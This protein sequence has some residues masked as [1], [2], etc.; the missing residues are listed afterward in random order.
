[1]FRVGAHLPLAVVSPQPWFPLQSLLRHFRPGTRLG[2]PAYA[3]QDGFDVWAP[4]FFSAPL[5]L[6]RLDGESMALG[7]WPRLQALRQAGRLDVLDAHF[8]YPDGY[9]GMRLKRRL[10]VPLTITMRGTEVRHARDPVLR[11]LLA[12]ALHGADRVFAVSE[13]LRQVA[14]DLG[15]APERTRVV[16]NGVDLSRFSRLPRD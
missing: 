14:L 4:R 8:G 13:S 3:C 9:A 15:V 16:G 5:L 12:Q 2:A 10:G 6:R 11:P 1:M 7:A